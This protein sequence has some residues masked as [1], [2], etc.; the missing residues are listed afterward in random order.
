MTGE[1]NGLMELKGNFLGQPGLAYA[2]LP[3]DED[4]LSLPLLSQFPQFQEPVYLGITADNSVTGP[5]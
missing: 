1:N 3:G 2:S 4:N 5:E